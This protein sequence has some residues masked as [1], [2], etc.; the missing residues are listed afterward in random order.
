LDGTTLLPEAPDLPP[1]LDNK[2]VTAMHDSLIQ[3][4]PGTAWLVATGALTNVALLFSIYPSLADHIAGLSIM[5]GA[6]GGFFSHAPLGR[7][8]ERIELVEHVHKV[9]PSGLHYDSGVT[10]QEVVRLLRE[11]DLLKHDIDEDE[12][13]LHSLLDEARGSFGNWTPY[14]EFNVSHSFWISGETC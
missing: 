4:P 3:T 6:V 7:L 1:N 5:G 14:A 11:L 2:A 9:I 13:R 8:R 12:E 10:I